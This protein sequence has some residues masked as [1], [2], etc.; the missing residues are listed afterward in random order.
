MPVLLPNEKL[1]DS[2][3][4]V[5][6]GTIGICGVNDAF[7]LYLAKLKNG[8]YNLI[9]FMK[10]QFYFTNGDGG[11]WMRAEMVQFVNDWKFAIKNKWGNKIIKALISTKKVFLDFRFK[12]QI[13]GWMLDHWEITVTKVSKF[14]TSSVNPITGNVKLDS[15]DLTLTKKGHNQSQRGAIHEFGHM[16]GL[17]DEYLKSSPHKNDYASVMNSG[18]R[19][20][21]RHDMPY[22]KWLEEKLKKHGI[23]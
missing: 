20:Y 23:K 5:R 22:M 12:T 17:P 13:D 14:A 2:E 6:A 9:V 18:E 16:L 10:V 1:V 7:D 3:S 15:L 11:N 4:D 21:N 19:V 8:N